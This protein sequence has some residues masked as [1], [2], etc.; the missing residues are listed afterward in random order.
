MN[1]K[2]F[3][4]IL[5]VGTE[6]ASWLERIMMSIDDVREEIQ[7]LRED[8]EVANRLQTDEQWVENLMEAVHGSKNKNQESDEN[9][10]NIGGIE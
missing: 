8:Y 4:A 1:D 9:G 7:S 3:E 6:I 2:Q 10:T 5:E